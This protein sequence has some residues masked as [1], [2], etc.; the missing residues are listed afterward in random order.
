MQN[1]YQTPIKY[2]QNFLKDG[3]LARKLVELSKLDSNDKVIEIGPG[4][5][6]LTKALAAKVS[7]VIAVEKD[8]ELAESLKERLV[9]NGI[10]NVKVY[11]SDF[12]SFKLPSD[13][14][15]VF[16]NIP[17][18]ISS[19]IIRKLFFGDYAPEESFLFL[20][21][22]VALKLIGRPQVRESMTSVLLKPFFE[23]KIVHRFSE[24]D[25]E[26]NPSVDIVLIKITKNE[27]AYIDPEYRKLYRNFIIY[28]FNQ[29]KGDIGSS[30]KKLFSNQQLK[31]ISK[32]VEIDM[33]MK[34]SELS[35]EEWF[36]LFESFR[37]YVPKD[38]QKIVFGS[39]EKLFEV[40]NRM[41]KTNF[42]HGHS[43]G[44][45]RREGLH[46]SNS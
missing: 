20:Q 19:E 26:P 3:S 30:V 42:E 21:K 45:G 38:K 31:I 37:Q 35:F 41:R 12:L 28:S 29:W 33:K 32:N 16:S 18:S 2:S 23:A 39:E 43:R 22:E 40:Q 34:P 7:E 8:P 25:F 9:E 6:Q 4:S 27:E 15:K 10:S 14:Y 13:S 46:V 11:N 1:K 24:F 17:F 36:Q 5:G 44:K